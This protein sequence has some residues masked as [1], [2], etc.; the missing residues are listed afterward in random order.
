MAG[1]IGIQP[2]P[3]ATQTRDTFT[4]TSNQTSFPTSG[5]TPE[6]LDVFMNGVHL[7]N[8]T[9]YTASNGSD[10]VLAVGA[11]TGDIIEVVAYSTF[12]MTDQTFTGTTT[13]GATLRAP[14]TFTIDP[15]VH[16]ANSGT[17]VIAGDLTVNGTTTTINSTTISSADKNITLGAG[18]TAS[19]NNGAGITIDGASASLTY[20]H[21]GTKF[22]FNKPLDVTGALSTT[23]TLIT[24][25]TLKVS[26]G[27]NGEMQFGL[28]TAL[29]TGAGTYDST[30]R[31]NGSSGN[32]LFSQGAVEKVRIGNS[33]LSVTGEIDAS[34]LLK[35]GTNNTEYANNYIRF[36]PAGAAYIDHNTVGQDINFRT[37][38]SSSLDT[39]P[40]VIKGNGNVGIGTINPT[41]HINTGSFLKPD[42]NGKFLTVNGGAHGSF[43]M[44][45]SSTTTDNDQIGGIYFTR[46]GGQSDAHRQ[47]AGIDVIQDAYAPNNTLEGGTLRFFTK[48]SGSSLNTPRMV[49]AGGGNVGIGTSSPGEKLEVNGILQIKRAG[50]HPAMRFVEGTTTRAYMGSGDWAVNGLADADFGISSVGKLAL[51]TSAG[52]GRLYILANGNVGIGT[53]APAQKLHVQKASGTTLVRTEVAA[54]SLVGFNIKKTGSTTQEWNIVD[55]AT[56][57]GRLQIQDVTDNR[58]DMTFD[59]TGKVGIGTTSPEVKLEVNGGAD[60]SVVFAGRSDGGNG[61]NRRFNLIA[62][63]DGGG[64]NYGGGLKI[65]TRSS[66]NVFDDAITVQSNGNVG[67]GEPTPDYGLHVNSGGTNVA[68]KFES[69]DG[70][71]GIML[72]DN[73]GNVELSTEGGNF[74]VQPAGGAAKLIVTSAGNAHL[75]GQIDARIQLSSSGSANTVSDNTV[76]VRGNDDTAILNAAANGDIKLSENGATRLMIERTT[77]ALIKFPVTGSGRS[78]TRVIARVTPNY[79]SS[80]VAGTAQTWYSPAVG[81]SGIIHFGNTNDS[82]GEYRCA[83]YIVFSRAQSSGAMTITVTES[84]GGNMVAFAV[85]GGDITVQN[86]YGYGIELMGR[87]E[88]FM[89]A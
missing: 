34:T 64:A 25:A 85:S 66:T 77:G 41:H 27:T 48:N 87:V 60:G 53:D 81:E 45:E 5:Y 86:T 51:G 57:N 73:A 4:A 31:W 75:S 12:T 15:A 76:Y 1:Y 83:G 62:Y 37:S 16:G 68:A 20:V 55:G 89:R 2:T 88:S 3:Q 40:V 54:G 24:A 29:T 32:L 19:A 61:N 38:V 6:F 7:L 74:Q 9:D 47:V 50:D 42:S 56:V 26:D 30:V 23:G 67:I 58:V 43:L 70:T 21:S 22:V 78:E 11:T 28:G 8:G 79:P 63:A 65:Q 69:T 59:G 84:I 80:G 14:S 49:I 35:V 46:T 82:G 13:M 10:V 36:K 52:A 18:A 33:G 72:A 44:L 17:V 39:T 71:A